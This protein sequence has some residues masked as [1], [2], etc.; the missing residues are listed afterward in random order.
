ML[1]IIYDESFVGFLREGI[2]MKTS[3]SIYKMLEKYMLHVQQE[4]AQGKD[5]SE[6]GLDEHLASGIAFGMGDFNLVLSM[7]PEI[8]LKLA[9]FVGFSGDRDVAMYYFRSVGGWD[10]V[11]VGKL[12]E[13]QG[14][15][16]G[17]RR[18][19][20]DMMLLLYNIVLSKLAPL[21]H[22]DEELAGRVLQYNLNLYPDGIFFLYFSG[23][24][25]SSLKKLEDA[26]SQ[27]HRAIEMQKDWKQL[28]HMCYW[29]LGLI[30]LIQQ[31]WKVAHDTFQL[32]N[33]ESNWSKAVYTYLQAVSLYLYALELPPGEKRNTLISNVTQLMSK[34]TKAKQKI[35]GKSIF[36]EVS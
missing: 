19:F 1:Q 29:E 31:K 6:Y 2:K 25:L 28:Q 4:A 36:V 13:K 18:Q 9:E 21:S 8:V 15:E 32:L 20:C 16:E 23:R 30:A 12:P 10:D 27:Y 33:N 35:A 5:V 26:K 7:L 3:H 24:Q 22:V 34:V 14:P 17:I 11:E